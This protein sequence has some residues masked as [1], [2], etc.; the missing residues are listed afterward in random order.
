MAEEQPAHDGNLCRVCWEPES[1]EPG[2]RFVD[3]CR[4]T[5]GIHSRCLMTWLVLRNEAGRERLDCCEVC[6]GEW[7]NS[8][9]VP[10][11][12][13]QQSLASFKR[14]QEERAEE[15]ERMLMLA[16]AMLAAED[17]KRQRRRRWVALGLYGS[18]LAGALTFYG[19]YLCNKGSGLSRG[20]RAFRVAHLSR[21][22]AEM[23]WHTRLPDGR[24]ELAFTTIL[25]SLKAA[26]P[27]S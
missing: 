4:C 12:A 1:A 3:A 23:D 22:L 26:S 11:A 9:T 24:P 13:L 20:F 10:V 18:F 25:H 8:L 21:G 14:G 16:A 15:L 2:G 6:T 7:R 27:A 5:S 19:V 17:A